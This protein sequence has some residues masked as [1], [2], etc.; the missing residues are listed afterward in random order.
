MRISI[1]M[2]VFFLAACSEGRESAERTRQ[3]AHDAAKVYAETMSQS[4]AT[5]AVQG[6]A[7]GLIEPSLEQLNRDLQR[8]NQAAMERLRNSSYSLAPIDVVNEDTEFARSAAAELKRP[9]TSWRCVSGVV[10]NATVRNGV[11][12]F[13]QVRHA[14]RTLVCPRPPGV[15]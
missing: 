10:V 11:S 8:R 4:K 6:V 14:G 2:T 3:Q 5:H 9:G 1:P 7:S 13:E 12:A 15:Y